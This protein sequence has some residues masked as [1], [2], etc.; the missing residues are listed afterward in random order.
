[1]ISV[2]NLFRKQ[3]LLLQNTQY[4]VI[5]VDRESPNT[6]DPVARYW[7]H[8]IFCDIPVS[9][10]IARSDLRSITVIVIAIIYM[11][12]VLVVMT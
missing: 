1:M 8:G 11:E 9:A 10:S 4:T 2:R 6:E 12:Y 5:I 7:V 3:F